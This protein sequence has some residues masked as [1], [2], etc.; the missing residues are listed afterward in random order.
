MCRLL[1]RHTQVLWGNTAEHRLAVAD[2]AAQIRNL[3]IAWDKAHQEG[4][5]SLERADY[6]AFG[7]VIAREGAI[8]K[9]QARALSA[10][11]S[12]TRARS[13]RQRKRRGS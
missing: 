2:A 9:R 3:K 13:T 7:R 5:A 4:L 12:P 6:E 1:R 8:I 10:I 11:Q